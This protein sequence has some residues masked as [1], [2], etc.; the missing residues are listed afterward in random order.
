MIPIKKIAPDRRLFSKRVDK[1]SR[2][3]MTA[4][5]A[6]HFRY[7]TMNGWNPVSYTHLTLPTIGG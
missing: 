3:A 6:N 4:Y 2:G 1:R 5:L 7:S